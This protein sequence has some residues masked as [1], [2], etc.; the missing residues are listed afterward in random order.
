[1]YFILL[2]GVNVRVKVNK[3]C[4]KN[5]LQSLSYVYKYITTTRVTMAPKCELQPYKHP[6]TRQQ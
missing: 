1:M 2:Q 3:R 5:P 4:N 6:R